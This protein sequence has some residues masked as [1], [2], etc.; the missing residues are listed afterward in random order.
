MSAFVFRLAPVL[1][2][3]E[4][5]RDER[6]GQLA[7]ALRLEEDLRERLDNVERDLTGALRAAHDAASPGT[8]NVDRLIDA[9]RYELTLRGEQHQML[10]QMQALAEEIDRR[11]MVLAAADRDVR[12]L[13][14]LREQQLE[15]HEADERKREQRLLDEAALRG[16]VG[17]EAR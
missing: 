8:V 10:R 9:E 7:E 1:R 11:R 13:E 2:L 6:R 3:R 14:K 4:A 15:R 16:F 12:V 5:T 17:E